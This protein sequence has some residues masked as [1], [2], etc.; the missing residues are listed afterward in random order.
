MTFQ[1]AAAFLVVGM[2]PHSDFVRGSLDLDEKGFVPVDGSFQT[3]LP[4]VFAAGDIRSRS[5][6]QLAAAVGDGV[7]AF[8]AVRRHLQEPVAR[9]AGEQKPQAVNE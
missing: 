7:A 8:M 6:R 3:S 2:Q 5:P 9:P 4:G 1:P